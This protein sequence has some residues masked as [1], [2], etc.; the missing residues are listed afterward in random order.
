MAEENISRQSSIQVVVR[1]RP[2]TYRERLM[3][4]DSSAQYSDSTVS[5]TS[6]LNDDLVLLNPNT[7]NENME[8]DPN[9]SLLDHW[10]HKAEGVRRVVEC[11]DD[12]MII[13]APRNGSQSAG[14][15]MS[16]KHTSNTRTKSNKDSGSLNNLKF[17]GLPNEPTLRN[18]PLNSSTSASHTRSITPRKRKLN[19]SKKEAPQRSPHSNFRINSYSNNELPNGLENLSS[20][21]TFLSR[22]KTSLIESRTTVSP[23]E[24]RKLAGGA[25]RRVSSPSPGPMAALPSTRSTSAYKREHRYIF[26]RVFDESSTQEE[27]YEY[28]T[29]PLLNS[30]IQGYNCTIFAYGA[31]GCGKT[32]TINGDPA[33]EIGSPE[34][35]NGLVYKVIQDLFVKLSEMQ[36]NENKEYELMVSY[37]EIYNE[38]IKDLLSPQTPSKK[39]IIREDKEQKIQVANL[40]Y[41]KPETLEDIMELIDFGNNYR[42]TNET[43]ANKTS[44]RSHSVLQISVVIKNKDLNDDLSENQ[45][46]SVLSIIDLAGSER[47]C[48]TQNRGARLQE[49][50]NINKSLLALGNCIKALCSGGNSGGGNNNVISA[51]GGVTLEPTS[52]N[53]GA[54]DIYTPHVPYRDSK[55]T[56][57]L[58]F[59]LGGNCKTVMIVCCSPSSEHYD[60]TLNTLAYAD[61]AKEIKTKLVKNSLNMNNHVGSYVKMIE[62]QRLEIGKLKQYNELSLKKKREQINLKI[63]EIIAGVETRLNLST[64][65]DNYKYTRSLILCKRRHLQ[66]L[67]MNFE[68]Y[69]QFYSAAFQESSQGKDMS[70][71]QFLQSVV[72]KLN[73]KIYLLETQYE[74]EEALI[75]SFIDY[76]NMISNLP[77]NIDSYNEVIDFPIVDSLIK[78]LKDNVLNEI[79]TN[80]IIM[81]EN[82]IKDYSG[83]AMI[84]MSVVKPRLALDSAELLREFEQFVNNID[85]NFEKFSAK[86][87]E[88]LFGDRAKLSTK[89]EHVFDQ[90][91]VLNNEA[92]QKKK[93]R[94][95]DT[96]AAEG[97]DLDIQDVKD[98]AN[99]VVGD[100]QKEDIMMDQS[101]GNEDIVSSLDNHSG[102][103]SLSRDQSIDREYEIANNASNDDDDDDEEEEE[104]LGN[105]SVV[106]NEDYRNE[107]SAD[108]NDFNLTNQLGF[109]LKERPNSLV[110]RK[111]LP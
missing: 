93:L 13:L 31:T 108:N 63:R 109:Q 99:E 76:E 46:S 7:S 97:L 103:E 111:L 6:L 70:I 27:V 2:F 45:L 73:E 96:E 39:L 101:D 50:A 21:P 23:T 71:P 81:V 43:N 37:L 25:T 72:G 62:R 54:Q 58:K 77:L 33:A 4:Q 75:D 29:K 8:L 32:Y 102:E 35:N 49:G 26:D 100:S 34:R 19:I 91:N 107:K 38:T 40:S 42:T 3:L 66:I 80:S 74:S 104:E 57:L 11:V 17:I 98:V 18:Q 22:R 64:K 105:Q 82:L 67:I 44:S 28:T 12:K 41:H 30:I 1:V 48:K 9:A 60:E 84:P 56:R 15:H 92:L 87:F 90:T 78:A 59:S 52:L 68:H 85:V 14:N 55:L 83:I 47:A 51:T 16:G 20:S 86:M 65:F 69:M 106:R 88:N 94:W 95:T 53:S 89:N 61:R 5:R 36:E 110:S 10:N 79:L 24:G